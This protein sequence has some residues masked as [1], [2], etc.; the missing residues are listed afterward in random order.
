MEHFGTAELGDDN[1][2]GEEGIAEGFRGLDLGIRV[3]EEL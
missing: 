3:L 1:V 2:V